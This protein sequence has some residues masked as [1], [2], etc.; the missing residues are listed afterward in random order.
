[1]PFGRL[2]R[3]GLVAAIVVAAWPGTA[4]AQTVGVI[5]GTVQDATGAVI[6][7]ATVVLSNPGTIGANQQVITDAQGASQFKHLVPSGTDAVQ[8]ELIGFR[9]ATQ[10][11]I[12]VD[13]GVIVRV[14]LTL[15]TGDVSETITVSSQAPLLDT[16][17]VA[18]PMVMDRA[19]LDALPTSNDIWSIGRLMPALITARYD[20]GG[21]DSLQQSSKPHADPYGGPGHLRFAGRVSQ[22]LRAR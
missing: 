2:S 8:A 21:S 20:V 6:P 22:A 10:N 18:R 19:S 15:Q 5:R 16:R 12:N 17:T 9:T 4:A 13:A 1:M 14:D 7:G 11:T 3:A